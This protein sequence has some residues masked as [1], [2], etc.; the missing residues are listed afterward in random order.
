MQGGYSHTSSLTTTSS[1]ISTPVTTKPNRYQPAFYN[2]PESPMFTTAVKEKIHRQ[3]AEYQ[4]KIIS[5]REERDRLL[6]QSQAIKNNIISHDELTFLKAETRS[7]ISLSNSEKL[8]ELMNQYLDVIADISFYKARC[9]IF[10]ENIKE[11]SERRTQFIKDSNSIY[12]T[13]DF[14]DLT[15]SCPT[16]HKHH[17]DDTPQ[18]IELEIPRMQQHLQSLKNDILDCYYTLKN[19]NPKCREAALESARSAES[20]WQLKSLGT[21]M[22][23]NEIQRLQHYLSNS[24]SEIQK[25]EADIQNERDSM[26]NLV[27]EQQKE[28]AEALSNYNCRKNEFA[29]NIKLNDQEIQKLSK[30]IELSSRYYDKIMNEIDTMSSQKNNQII[31]I[32]NSESIEENNETESDDYTYNIDQ[33]TLNSLLQKKEQYTKEIEKLKHQLNKQKKKAKLKQNKLLVEIKNLQTKN[34]RCREILNDFQINQ[35]DSDS[36]AGDIKSLIQKIDSS[37]TELHTVINE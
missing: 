34:R 5:L 15:C 13:L 7:E 36:L 31:P 17:F 28:E 24:E 14:S 4:A 6:K 29:D 21:M 23:R 25:Y 16:I 8:K 35:D 1:T 19:E 9:S 20:Q 12:Q 30:Q 10:E 22:I 26:S 33:N 32:S 2:T 18:K 27:I 3:N 11:E 37:L